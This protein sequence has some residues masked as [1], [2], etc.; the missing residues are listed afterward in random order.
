MP[1]QH[2]KTLP[3]GIC[4]RFVVQVQNEYFDLL[5]TGNFLHYE[6]LSRGK[7]K[8]RRSRT[9]S[10]S[11]NIDPPTHTGQTQEM[12]LNVSELNHMCERGFKNSPGVTHSSCPPQFAARHQVAAADC[13]CLFERPACVNC[14]SAQPQTRRSAVIVGSG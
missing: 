12:F 3:S 11:L 6:K 5:H 1:E 9:H 2:W 7:K 13:E 10:I 14:G 8:K 4:R